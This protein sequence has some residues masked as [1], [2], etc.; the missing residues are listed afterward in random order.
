MKLLDKLFRTGCEFLGVKYPI[1]AGAMTWIS[2]HRLVSAVS[3]EGGLGCLA[4]G[5][6]DPSALALEIDRTRERTK[7]PFGINLI[8]IAPNY[9][10]QLEVV[11]EKHHPSSF[12]TEAFP[13]HQRFGW[14]R[15]VG[16]RCWRFLPANR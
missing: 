15:I 6:M 3:N 9:T 13:G 14:P 1:M 16:R 12:L 11:V 8:T 2:D 7:N 10:K 5:N 4:G